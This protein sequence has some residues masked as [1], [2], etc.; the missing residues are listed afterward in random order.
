M[1][2]SAGQQQRILAEQNRYGVSGSGFGTRWH[3]FDE[4]FDA[5]KHPNEPNRFGWVV[6]I[7]PFDPDSIPIKRTALGRIKHEGVTLSIAKDNRVVFY[8]GDDERNEYVYKFVSRDPYNPNDLSANHD[9]LDFGTL[10]VARFNADGTGAWLR[11]VHGENG[12]TPANGF[13]DQAEVL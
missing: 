7:D 8:T 2:V 5:S 3:E 4:R 9:L 6:E 13:A 10:Y 1:G 12:L 11:L